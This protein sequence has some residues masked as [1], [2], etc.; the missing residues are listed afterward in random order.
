MEAHIHT[1]V[2]LN[3]QLFARL[4]YYLK[5]TCVY[6]VWGCCIIVRIVVLGAEVTFYVL[7]INY[8]STFS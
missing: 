5:F 6:I 4:T 3:E 8:Q 2:Y 1:Y 7:N